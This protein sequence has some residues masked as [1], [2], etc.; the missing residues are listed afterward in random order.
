MIF[1]LV[2]EGATDQSVITNIIYGVFGSKDT[3][4]NILPSS[5]DATNRGVGPLHSNWELVL[6]YISSG[7]FA[8]AFENSDFHYIVIHVDTDVCDH[9]NFDVSKRDEEGNSLDPLE[10]IKRVQANLIERIDPHFWTN[11]SSQIIFAIAVDS[12]E[13]W[14]LPL[15]VTAQQKAKYS[16]CLEALNRAL[17]KRDRH[18]I[19]PDRKD[20]RYYDE[21]SKSYSRHRELSEHYQKNDGLRIFVKRL[22]EIP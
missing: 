6:Q 12:V 8:E 22:R 11:H 15:Y 14:L 19:N 21:I 5:G 1:G 7:E 10:L 4:V 20:P 2:R 16:G 3:E 17:K 18:P 9:A 13:C